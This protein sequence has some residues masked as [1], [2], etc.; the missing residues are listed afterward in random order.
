MKEQNNSPL[1]EASTK[2]NS[3][4]VHFQLDLPLLEVIAEIK[5]EIE[6]LSAQAGLEIIHHSLEEGLGEPLMVTRLVLP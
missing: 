2:F 3:H 5:A 6:A 1:A 4:P